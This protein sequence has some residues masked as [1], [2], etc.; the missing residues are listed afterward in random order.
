MDKAQLKAYY[1]SRGW[2]IQNIPSW[3]QVSSEGGVTTYSVI[4]VSPK[5]LSGSTRVEVTD[6]GTPSE[7]AVVGQLVAE[8]SSNFENDVRA[9]VQAIES[10]T[11]FATVVKTVYENDEVAIVTAYLLDTADSDRDGS[12][13]DYVEKEY[14]VKRRQGQFSVAGL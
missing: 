13:T 10:P 5:G 14:V 9:A 12:T 2:S 1:E 6:E 3:R 8:T 11:V 4:A 7:T